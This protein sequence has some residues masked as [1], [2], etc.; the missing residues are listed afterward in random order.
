MCAWGGSCGKKVEKVGQYAQENYV[1]IKN[2]SFKDKI[3]DV[4][5]TT[6]WKN[7]YPSVSA[8]KLQTW[9]IYKHLKDMIPDLT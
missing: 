2:P 5:E 1:Y 3:I 4:M 6:D 9:K 7:L 8:P